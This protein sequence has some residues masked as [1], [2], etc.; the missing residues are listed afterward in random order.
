VPPWDLLP[1]SADI[2]LCQRARFH[3]QIDFSVNVGRIQRYMSKPSTNGID[4]DASTQ[5][6]TGSRMSKC[7]GANTLLCDGW[8]LGPRL[9]RVA[10]H[11]CVNAKAS[12]RLA[13]P[14]EEDPFIWSTLSDQ[15]IKSLYGRRS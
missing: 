3:L 5:Q 2:A 4:I 14:I 1:F 6:M 8:C 11:K 15:R 12:D 9:Q 13:A 7:V 10:R